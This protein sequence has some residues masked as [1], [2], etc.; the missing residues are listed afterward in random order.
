MKLRA[1]VRTQLKC[2]HTLMHTYPTFQPSGLPRG[3]PG[4][5]GASL[6][7]DRDIDFLPSDSMFIPDPPHED[8]WC[9]HEATMRARAKVSGRTE[10]VVLSLPPPPEYTVARIP[11]RMSLD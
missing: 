7:S 1:P 2:M 3:P 4:T 11:L 8:Y 5:L 9:K 6:G 10:S